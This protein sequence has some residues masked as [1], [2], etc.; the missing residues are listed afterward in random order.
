MFGIVLWLEVRREDP[1]GNLSVTMMDCGRGCR[2]CCGCCCCDV[3]VIDDAE[4]ESLDAAT[5]PVV[6]ADVEKYRVI[7]IPVAT[8]SSSSS[9]AGS[10]SS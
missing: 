7:S 5:P 3:V 4:G 10:S 9:F 8:V 1:G 6:M 2:G